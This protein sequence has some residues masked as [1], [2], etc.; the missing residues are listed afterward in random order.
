MYQ[1]DKKLRA[2]IRNF[3]RAFDTIMETK[4]KAQTIVW[5]K[6]DDDMG[7]SSDTLN[8]REDEDDQDDE[9]ILTFP[10]YLQPY[11]DAYS[12]FPDPCTRQRITT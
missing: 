8:G 3:N 1:P 12:C 9:R 2:L 6:S 7:G 5:D 11:A 4:G 10:K